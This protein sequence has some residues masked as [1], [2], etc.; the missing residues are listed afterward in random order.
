VELVIGTLRQLEVTPSATL[1]LAV[2]AAGMGQN[3]FAPPNVKG[4]PGG[5][6]WI[7]SASLL[8]RKQYLERLLRADEKATTGMAAPGADGAAMRPADA[9]VAADAA[10]ERRARAAFQRRMEGAAANLQFDSARWLAALPGTTPAE[11]ARSAQRLLLPIDP[12]DSPPADATSQA[13]V[14]ALLQ[15]PAYQLK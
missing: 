14:R 10:G 3:L 2:L 13:I 15:E 8:A 7:N 6:Q 9:A 1:P 5:E 11:H 12:P 4:W